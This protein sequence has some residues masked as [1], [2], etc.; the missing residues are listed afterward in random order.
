MRIALIVRHFPVLSQTFILNQ[1]TG[2][3]DRNHEVDIYP[4]EGIPEKNLEKVH[5]DVEKYHLL[6]RTYP[7]PEISSNYALRWLNGWKLLAANFAKNPAVVLR[8]LNIF[9][10]GTQQPP[11]GYSMSPSPPWTKNL[12]TSFTVNLGTWDYGEFLFGIS[13]SLRLN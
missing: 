8:S 13:V 2:L 4:L 10:Y 1:I 12:M 6:D 3:I 11:S 7:L 9:K 5:P